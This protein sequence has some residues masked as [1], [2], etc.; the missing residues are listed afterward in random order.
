[1]QLSS[2]ESF[3]NERIFGVHASERETILEILQARLG[4]WF[5]DIGLLVQ[6]MIHRSYLN[7]GGGPDQDN[8]RLEFL[9][10]AVIDL[11]VSTNLME[12]YPQCRE[13][14]L[15]QL[16]AAVVSRKGLSL[17]AQKIAL[18]EFLL[19][20][21]GEERS[22]GKNKDSILVGSLEAL[23]G[24]IYLDAGILLASSVFWNLW[25]SDVQS[26]LSQYLQRDFK[27]QLQALTQEKYNCIPGYRILQVKGPAHRQAFE[28]EVSIDDRIRGLGYGRSKKEAEQDAA[29]TMLERLNHED[30][31][32]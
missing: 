15:S 1:M 9:G 3:E 2:S 26:L 7:E 19:L 13:G 18:G 6:A 17:L 20:G 31:L 4:Y 16:R 11:I 14:D 29:M 5:K 24:A 28:V 8:E 10:D 27:S 25:E 12:R 21:K 30:D 32:L 23:M 22:G